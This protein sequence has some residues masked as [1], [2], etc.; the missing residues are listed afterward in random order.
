VVLL[1]LLKTVS[2]KAEQMF[3]TLL[4]IKIKSAFLELFLKDHVTLKTGIKMLKNHRNNYIYKIYSIKEVIL[5]C[6]DFTIL[7]V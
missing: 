7:L 5:S 4:I 6:N 1:T 3:S 2:T